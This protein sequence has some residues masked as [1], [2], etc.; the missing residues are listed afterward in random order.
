MKSFQQMVA[1]QVGIKGLYG[2]S[3]YLLLNFAVILKLL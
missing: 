1:E 3:L 2:K